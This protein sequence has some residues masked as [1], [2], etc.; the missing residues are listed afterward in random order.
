MG[1]TT[2]V[3]C[4]CQASCPP[5]GREAMVTVR[6]PASPGSLEHQRERNGAGVRQDHRN[7]QRQLVQLVATSVPRRDSANSTKA[8]PGTMIVP[9]ATAWSASHGCLAAD[10]WLVQHD[11]V[12]QLDDGI[13]QWM[14]ARHQTELGEVASGRRRR[15]PVPLVLERIGRQLDRPR[16]R[17]QRAPVQRRHRGRRAPSRSSAAGRH[18]RH[19]DAATRPRPPR[20]RIRPG[21]PAGRPSPPDAD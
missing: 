15:L 16:R 2:A 18:R 1:A 4:R 19:R 7:L 20:G 13:D 8:V 6:T 5:A 14:L 12:R 11:R 10:N 21:G 9:P 17:I 3:A